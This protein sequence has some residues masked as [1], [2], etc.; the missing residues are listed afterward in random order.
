MYCRPRQATLQGQLIVGIAL[1][2]GLKYP[3]R[4]GF[5]AERANDPDWDIEA[6]NRSLKQKRGLHHAP[7]LSECRLKNSVL[8]FLQ[9]ANLDFDR[10]RLGREPLFLTGE[11]VLAEALGLGRN[12]QSDYFQEAGQG[13]FAD[14]LLAHR[15]QGGG[16]EGGQHRL[17]SLGLD[18]RVLG[19][20]GDQS[21]LVQ[22][23]LDRLHLCWLGSDRLCSSG[24]LGRG[25]GSSRFLGGGFGLG[26]RGFLG[27]H[28]DSR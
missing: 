28:G 26:G 10:G 5:C 8:Q 16:F 20:M 1:P 11:G 3:G 21:G 15:G 27:C 7:L 6:Q 14:A 17:D 2:A 22:G 9:G 4:I 18:A 13:E 24:L 23:S 12:L 25:F 19:Q